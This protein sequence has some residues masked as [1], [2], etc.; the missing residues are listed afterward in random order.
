MAHAEAVLIFVARKLIQI[1]QAARV[2]ALACIRLNIEIGRRRQ[3][4]LISHDQGRDD[5]I[6][7]SRGK[8]AAAIVNSRDIGVDSVTIATSL[9]RCLKPIV[10]VAR[11]E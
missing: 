4:I 5:L 3:L 9:E 11:G 8:L 1:G 7:L 10:E 6:V 2:S